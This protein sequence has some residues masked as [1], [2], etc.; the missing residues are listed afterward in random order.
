MEANWVLVLV[1]AAAYLIMEII[2]A[3][4]DIYNDKKKK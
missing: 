3:A 1:S 4:L 2:D